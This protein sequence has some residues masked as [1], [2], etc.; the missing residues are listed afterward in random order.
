MSFIGVQLTYH[1][2]LSKSC[3]KGV[4]SAMSPIMVNVFDTLRID[5]SPRTAS[6]LIIYDFAVIQHPVMILVF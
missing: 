6:Q 4:N 5:I 2:C 3:P 1:S